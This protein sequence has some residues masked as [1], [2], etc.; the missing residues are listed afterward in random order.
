MDIG[1]FKGMPVQ[2]AK[3]EI[4]K[5]LIKDGLAHKYYEP[6]EKVVS[7]SGETCVVTEADQW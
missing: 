4:R 1:P 5:Q 6:S 3:D 7:R 2:K